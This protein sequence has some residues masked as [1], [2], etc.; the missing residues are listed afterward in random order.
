MKIFCY[1]EIEN[2]VLKKILKLDCQSFGTKLKSEACY[3]CSVER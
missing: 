1:S 3:N 2:V